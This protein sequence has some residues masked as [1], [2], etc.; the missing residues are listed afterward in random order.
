MIGSLGL[1]GREGGRAAGTF[2]VMG[3]WSCFLLRLSDLNEVGGVLFM[4]EVHAGV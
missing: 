3:G 4:M 1:R 2:T